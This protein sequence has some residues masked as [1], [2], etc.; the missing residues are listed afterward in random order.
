MEK[1]LIL[2]DFDK[3]LFDTRGFFEE[4][5]GPAL[6]R[7][8]DLSQNIVEKISKTYRETLTKSTQFDPEGWLE[9]AQQHHDLDAEQWRTLLQNPV[10]YERSLFPEVIPTL[11]ELSHDYVLGIYSEAVYEWQ[12][13]KISLSGLINYFDQKYIMISSDK[14]S[15]GM[16]DQIPFGAM[17]VD[18]KLEVIAA[19]KR[20]TGIYPIWLNRSGLQGMPSVREIRDLSQILRVVEQ[21]RASGGPK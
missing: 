13:K 10:F 18:D 5:L 9:V 17:I 11:I 1:Q 15:D 7:E 19:L 3:T 14:V 20:R 21:I 6:E 16:I 4:Q 8:F 12:M 2:F